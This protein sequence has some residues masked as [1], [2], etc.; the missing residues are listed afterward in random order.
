MKTS[1]PDERSAIQDMAACDA[2]PTIKK[3]GHR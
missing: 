1:E 3:K 2:A